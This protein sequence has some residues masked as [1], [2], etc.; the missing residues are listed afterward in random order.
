[1]D[2]SLGPTILRHGTEDQ[3]R[4]YLPPLLSGAELW[5]QGFSEPDAGSDLAGLRTNA[6]REGDEFVITGQKIWTS[7]ATDAD[8]C[9]VLAR[10]DQDAP[11][12][13]GISYLLVD[14]RSPGVT[15]KPIVQITGD[16]EFNEI[17][18]DQVR[19]PADCVLGGLGDGWS[20]AMDTL[21]HERGGYAIRRR[22]EN[23]MAF[24]DLV[25]ALQRVDDLPAHTALL[26][27]EL[28]VELKA[29]EAQSRGTADRLQAGHGPSPLD[30]LD[31]LGL[32]RTEQY[33]YSVGAEVLGAELMVA[34]ARPRGLDAEEWTKGLLYSRAASVYG[35]SEQIQRTI[36]AERLLELPRI[37]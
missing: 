35:G 13:K 12:H 19:V 17:F 28:F 31:K 33:L 27:G 30:S 2:P 20:L 4:R 36:V 11:K 32:S 29:F 18:F 9:A 21:G 1:M 34:G 15:I 23:E 7:W 10:T 6:V 3:R 8:W 37:R 26:V 5:C 25:R 24:H 14:L 16:A 22:L